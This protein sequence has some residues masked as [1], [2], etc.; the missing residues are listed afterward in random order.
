MTTRITDSMLAV[1][2]AESPF[3]NI[4]SV[5]NNSN[6]RNPFT[7]GTPDR[8]YSSGI[9]QG[10]WR[11]IRPH[12]GSFDQMSDK[13]EGHVSR[14]DRDQKQATVLS[15]P[16]K[17]L[18]KSVNFLVDSGAERSVMLKELIPASLLFPCDIKLT[19]VGGNPVDTF[20]EFKGKI[21]V[22]GLQREFS[23][24]FIASSLKPIL[25]ADF[26]TK[27]GL[28]LDMKKR[29]LH[30]PLTSI[31]AQINS[32]TDNHISLRVSHAYG[33]FPEILSPFRE[34]TVP[35]DYSSI[36]Q[37]EVTH[38]IKT[39]DTPIYCKPRSLFLVKIQ[40]EKREF[41]TL[42]ELGIVRPSSSS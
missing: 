26:L 12:P 36:P 6:P 38:E 41:D 28:Q 16:V 21:G 27:H 34:L 3:I 37:T 15:L 13:R 20:G 40:I 17:F 39:T 1:A 10:H 33:K 22:P 8:S 18:K 9:G 24:T 30:D 35:P 14:P 2:S 42:L 32:F 5:A 25:G 7:H 31:S 11:T 29:R 4:N 23:V 19:G